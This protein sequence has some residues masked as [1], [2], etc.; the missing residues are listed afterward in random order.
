[1]PS[2]AS[3]SYATLSTPRAASGP[4][5]LRHHH[6]CTL[7]DLHHGHRALWDLRHDQHSLRVLQNGLAPSGICT[8]PS[9]LHCALWE[10]NHSLRH[11]RV[12]HHNLRALGSALCDL[13]HALFLRLKLW[14]HSDLPTAGSGY[15]HSYLSYSGSVHHSSI[16]GGGSGRHRKH[17]NTLQTRT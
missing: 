1:M 10:H 3:G 17:T 8:S 12:M 11:L 14:H 13:N 16:T 7:R 2:G 9:D 5:V 4:A 6:L 15:G